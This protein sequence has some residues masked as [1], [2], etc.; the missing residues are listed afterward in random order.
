MSPQHTRRPGKLT[1]SQVDGYADL[2]PTVLVGDDVDVPHA[3]DPSAALVLCPGDSRR[4]RSQRRQGDGRNSL[5]PGGVNYRICRG[6]SLLRS[7]ER[8]CKRVQRT[9]ITVRSVSY[10]QRGGPDPG[11]FLTSASIPPPSKSLKSQCG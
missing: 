2:Q 7:L 6:R 4:R 9:R 5:G 8:T 1:K 11:I 10:P 3:R